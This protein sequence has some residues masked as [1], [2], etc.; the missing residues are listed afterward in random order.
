MNILF[1]APRI[2]Y[3]LN[4]GAKIRTF[5]LLR[6]AHINGNNVTMLSFLYQTEEKEYLKKIAEA[7]IKTETIPGKDKITLRTALVSLLKREPVAIVKYYNKTMAETIARLIKN[8][9]IDLV[10]F[11]HIHMG[12]YA[13][14]CSNIPAVIDEHNVESL[15]LKRLCKVENNFFK[16]LA[17]FDQ[18]IKMAALEKKICCDPK[19]RV[20]VVSEED[21]KNLEQLCKNQVKAEVIPNGV[22]TEFF[23]STYH[24][25]EVPI[26]ED[27]LVFL[28]SMDWLPN[29]DA[30]EYFYKDILPL[31][32]LKKPD[33]KF[34]ILGKKPSLNIQ[35]L[36]R[37]DSRIIVTGSLEDIRP[38]ISKTKVFVVPLRIGGGTRLKILDALAMG[39]AVI[40]TSI[41]AEGIAVENGKHLLIADTAGEFAEKIIMLLENNLLRRKLE[42]EGRKLVVKNYDWQI[43]GKKLDSAYQEIASSGAA[44]GNKTLMY[45]SIGDHN[46][47]EAGAGLYRVPA[48]KFKKQMEIIKQEQAASRPI[49]AISFDDGLEDNFIN[50]YP[51]L[52]ELGLK[53]YFFVMPDKIGTKGYM[54][55]EQIKELANYGM[56]IGSHGMTHRILTELDSQELIYEIEVSKKML[57]EKLGKR[58]ESFSIPK[59]YYDNKVLDTIKKAGYKRTFTS[60]IGI[61]NGLTAGRIAVRADWPQGYFKR[62]ITKGVPLRIQAIEVIKKMAKK[63][64]GSRLYRNIR[65]TALN[66][67]KS[68]E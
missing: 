40:S 53:A 38:V 16:K 27:A 10:H 36:G 41:G 4:T 22:D 51:V 29:E 12:Q 55:W 67:T 61:S 6:Q 19:N 63:L 39:K 59:G 9:A 44:V 60:D 18:F 3:P 62:I 31:V 47:D 25:G 65:E 52:K 43:I 49:P 24:Q 13:R 56:T 30:V 34:Y 14:F 50:A 21:K 68:K 15:I 58:I 37:I 1:V 57:Q 33:L 45:H 17:I 23:K 48:D 28:G 8:S 26:E 42:E 66:R 11:D 35:K 46:P 5:N 2:P 54:N 64:I 32:W 7:G 20:F